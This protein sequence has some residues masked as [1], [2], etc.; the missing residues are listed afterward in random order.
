MWLHTHTPRK[1]MSLAEE[2]QPSSRSK[3]C[4]NGR[5]KATKPS[6]GTDGPF[7]SKPPFNI[8]LQTGKYA[9]AVQN[10]VKYFKGKENLSK[11]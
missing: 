7:V 9:F 10:K 8:L 1:T 4:T 11:A 5:G 2:F 3:G 6:V